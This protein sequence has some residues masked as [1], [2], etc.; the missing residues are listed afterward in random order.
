M[1]PRKKVKQKTREYLPPSISFLVSV[2]FLTRTICGKPENI[3]PP[4]F[5]G[6]MSFGAIRGFLHAVINPELH[7]AAAPAPAIQAAAG[8]FEGQKKERTFNQMKQLHMWAMVLAICL[9]LFCQTVA[10][11]QNLGAAPQVNVAVQGRS[12]EH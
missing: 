10:F 1:P 4:P 3:C 9:A 7:T 6:V 8:C 11:A 12:E 5:F 2:R